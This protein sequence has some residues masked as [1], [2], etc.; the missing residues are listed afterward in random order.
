VPRGRSDGGIQWQHPVGVLVLGLGGFLAGVGLLLIGAFQTSRSEAFVRSSGFAVWATAVGAQT[1]FWL[2][3]AGPLWSDVASAWRRARIGRA[4]MVLLAGA[5]ILI[6]VV[7][8]MLSLAREIPWPLWG[9]QQKVRVLTVVGGLLVGV[10]ALSGIALVQQRVR[11]RETEPIDT[12][13][14]R[15]GIE[16]RSEILQY[17]FLAGAVIGLAVLSAGALREA[18]VPA[19]V[20]EDRFPQE[21]VLLYGAFF[22]GLLL[23][24]YVPAHLTL[25]HLG[26]KVRDHYFPL[27]SMPDPDADTL[28][29]WLDKRTTLETLLQLNVTPLQQ[30]QTSLF[31]LAPLLSAIL[32]SLTPR[33]G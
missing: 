9:H 14:V 19:F 22:T 16:A 28:R 32:T 24:V 23:L 20:P 26:V 3:V 33:P 21:G 15:F 13:D 8:P 2:L 30:L 11:R 31:I 1:A 7:F 27:S 12:D 18:T 10:P 4:A 29:G 6:L 25:K 5:L 17:L